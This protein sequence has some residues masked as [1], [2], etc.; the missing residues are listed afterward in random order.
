MHRRPQFEPLARL[1]A[2]GCGLFGPGARVGG[3]ILPDA[4]AGAL[5]LA[6]A[7]LTC[8]VL[9][10]L[11]YDKGGLLDMLYREAKV[12][13]VDYSQTIDITAVCSPRVLGRVA[14]YLEQPAE[15]EA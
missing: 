11:P 15:G 7:R 6:L 9:L 10:R 5:S 12:E 1:A 13:Q 14:P 4:D 3:I 8:R 2:A